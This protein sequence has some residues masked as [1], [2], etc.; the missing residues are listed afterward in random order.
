MKQAAQYM[1][2]LYEEPSFYNDKKIKA[3][4]FIEEKLNLQRISSI[5]E[6]RI[7]QIQMNQD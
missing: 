1:R 5:I 2:K 3:K 4:E 6:D 7:K